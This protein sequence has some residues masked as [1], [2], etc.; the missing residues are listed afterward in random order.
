MQSGAIQFI[1]TLDRTSLTVSDE[2]FERNVEAAVSEIAERNKETESPSTLPPNIPEK[3]APSGPQVTQRNSMEGESYSRRRDGQQTSDSLEDNPAV[4]GLLRTIQK[5]LSTI[6][7]IFSDE[8]G[9]QQE[10]PRPQQQAQRLSPAVFRTPQNS[11]ESPNPSERRKPE[12]ETQQQ[13][14]VRV[15]AQEAAARQATAEAAEARRIYRAEHKDV[16]E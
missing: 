11:E 8:T 12:G 3:S 6:G 1:E 7:K 15:D 5:P 14:A 4:A 2:D 16:V 9:S 13:Q 10:A